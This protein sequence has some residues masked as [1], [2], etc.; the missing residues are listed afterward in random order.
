VTTGAGDAEAP[1]RNS[2]W[3]AARVLVVQ[4]VTLVALWLL[5]TTFGS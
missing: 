4:V 2:R 3:L 5:Q 1:S